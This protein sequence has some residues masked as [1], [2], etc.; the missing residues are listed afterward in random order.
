MQSLVD[1]FNAIPSSHRALIL[2]GGI[3]FF[4]LVESAVPL[5]NFK[6]NKF[7]HAG[8]NIFFTITTIVVNFALAFVLVKTSDFVAA[9]QFGLLFMLPT[10]PLWLTAIVGMLL[11][12]LVGAYTIHFIEHR[13]PWMWRFHLVHHSDQSVDTTTANRH[14]PGESVFRLVFTCL[15]VLLTGAPIWVIFL[16]QTAS[17]V[18]S[19]FNHANIVLP[20]KIDAVL[21]WV[22]VT[23]NVHHVHHH[24]VLPHTDTNFGNIFSVWDRLFGTFSM[25]DNDKII[26]GIDTHQANEEHSNIGTILKVPFGKYRKP[27]L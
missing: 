23:P 1:Y 3:T 11:L 9:K 17:A 19:Q 22:I 16:Y 12:D 10:M 18:L 24:Y 20:K 5:F 4:W 13:I 26:Y 7:K 8:V 2:V 25:M 14:H 27:I 21:S 6:Y 15:A